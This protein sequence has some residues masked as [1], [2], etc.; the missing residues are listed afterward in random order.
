MINMYLKNKTHIGCYQ[1]S[2]MQGTIIHKRWSHACF[3]KRNW[4]LCKHKI[5]IYNRKWF[6]PF[7]SSQTRS[8]KNWMT[9]L[10]SCDMNAIGDKS[11]K[12]ASKRQQSRSYRM[13]ANR[14]SI[15]TYIYIFLHSL[16]KM[17]V[18]YLVFDSQ[19]LP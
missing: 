19:I 17:Q 6:R 15:N 13:N 9:T 16:C 2:P 4:T 18:F 8:I 1:F 14:S 5:L 7:I 11:M 12:R 3:V 10:P